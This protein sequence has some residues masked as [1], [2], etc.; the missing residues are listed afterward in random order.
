M[1][2]QQLF[3]LWNRRHGNGLIIAEVCLAALL[4]FVIVGYA[5]H[6]ALQLRSPLGFEYKDVQFVWVANGFPT[7]P[8][9]N[10]RVKQ[11]L[12]AVRA[13]PDVVGASAGGMA[14]FLGWR[15]QSSWEDEEGREFTSMMNNFEV[16]ADEV[17]KPDV[18]AGRW[19]DETDIG[20]E[21]V[22]VVVNR[23]FVDEN[24]GDVDAV[25]MTLPAP[26]G[27]ESEEPRRAKIV[28]VL[29]A[30]KQFS[31]LLP[32]EPYMITLTDPD[33]VNSNRLE[34]RPL[35]YLLVRRQPDAPASFSADLTTMLKRMAPDMPIRV[36]SLE[37]M[38]DDDIRR[39]LRPL[40]IGA[41][42]GGFFLLLVCFG[43][44]GIFWQSV[45][46]RTRELG[47]KRALGL[48]AGRVISHFIME[49]LMLSI[50]ALVIATV[51][52]AHL[53]LTGWLSFLNWPTFFVT[54][55][56]VWIG[57]LGLT[58]LCGAYPAWQASRIPPA[59][60]LRYE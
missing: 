3:L 54:L 53:P 29:S 39:K 34:N 10:E 7:N 38:R 32:D 36:Q 51:L 20:S 22:P 52:L 44:F 24:L 37:R 19:F 40:R 12:E 58:V 49:H 31:A 42:V 9:H 55:G 21:D 17:L 59:E 18:V 43:L 2:R 23:A 6:Y 8:A 25:G 35:I 28:G 41:L 15:S 14:L 46:T 26:G 47:V 4:T 57:I 60:A 45:T 50:A 33:L 16:R 5:V 56:V 11:L 27:D 30:F 13:R 48:S 1:L